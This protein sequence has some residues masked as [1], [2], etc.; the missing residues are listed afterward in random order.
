V[1]L[2][3]TMIAVKV[4]V[5][6]ALLVGIIFP[7]AITGISQLLFPSNSNGSLILKDG[8]VIGSRLVGQPFSKPDYFHPRP[9][10]AGAGYAGEASGGTNLGPTS[11]KLIIGQPDDPATKT[12]DES[13]A[14]VKQLAEQYRSENGL[15]ADQL[16]PVDAVT[17]S[18]SGLDPDIST[19]NAILQAA[20]VAK[21]RNL[22]EQQVLDLIA[23]LTEPRQL[24]LLGD[25]RVNVLMLNIALDELK[26]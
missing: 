12:V 6:L 21:A 20:R 15:P 9:S 18:G 25:P 1:L 16:V 22:P 7:V 26:R 3:N 19:N 10:A 11:K 4:S 17:R 8:K 23:R 13:F 14:G 5:V 24:S 2:K